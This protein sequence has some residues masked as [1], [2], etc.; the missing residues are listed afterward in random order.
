[1]FAGEGRG[2]DSSDGRW[3]A[4]REAILWQIG[5]DGHLVSC[6]T[7]V[8]SK[9]LA[10]LCDNPLGVDSCGKKCKES[11]FVSHLHTLAPPGAGPSLCCAPL[12]S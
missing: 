1:M 11:V 10:T 4:L 2:E 5:S 6:D 3:E 12:D 7:A 8:F 9:L